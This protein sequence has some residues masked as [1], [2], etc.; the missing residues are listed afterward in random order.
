MYSNMDNDTSEV[1]ENVSG[2][3]YVYNK[4]KLLLKTLFAQLYITEQ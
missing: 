2:Y 1:N 3:K 4:T